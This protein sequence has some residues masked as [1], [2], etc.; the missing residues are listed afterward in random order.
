MLVPKGNKE[1]FPIDLF[2]MISDYNNDVVSTFLV[3]L[4]VHGLPLLKL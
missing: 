3:Y 4:A 2:V 1:G